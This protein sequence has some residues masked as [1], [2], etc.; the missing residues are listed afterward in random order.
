MSLVVSSDAMSLRTLTEIADKQIIRVDPD[1][2]RR[3]PG[4]AWAAAAPARSTSSSTS[5]S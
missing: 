2:R 5:R 3:R 4:D 1:R